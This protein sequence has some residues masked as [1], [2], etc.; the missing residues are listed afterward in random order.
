[1][2]RH[3]LNR[4]ER[5]GINP[6]NGRENFIS[7]MILTVLMV[8][9][10]ALVPKIDVADNPR[11]RQGK[12]LSIW[13]SWHGA[14]AKVVEQNVTSRIEGLVSAVRGVERVT[15]ESYFGSGRVNVELKKSADV[16]AT[17]FE[18][19]SLLRQV[20]EQLPEGVSYPELSGGEVVNESRKKEMT[21]VLLSYRV[22][23][24][25][26]DEQLKEYI[27]RQVEPQLRRIE[28][29]KRVEVTGGHSKYIVITYDP[30]ILA[31][32]GLSVYDIENGIKAFLGKCDVVGELQEPGKEEKRT[33]FLTTDKFHG[34]LEEMP[35]GNV[36]G[37]TVYLND[38]ATYEYKDR[39]PGSYYRVNGL[40]TIYLNIHVDADANK[41]KLSRKLRKQIGEIEKTLRGGVYL[42]L[43]HDGAEEKVS[44][45]QKLIWRSMLSLAILLLF[46]WLVRR[47]WRYLS[48]MVITLAANIALAVIAYYIFDIRLHIY[49]LAGITVSLGMVIDASVVMVDHYSYYH[50]RKAFM[51]IL[52]ALLTTIGALVVVLW[53]PDFLQKD[54]YDFAWII[55]VNLSVALVVAYFF[56]PALIEQMR[57]HSRQKGEVKRIGLARWW[58]RCYR[59]YIRFTQKRKWIYFVILL[60]A[61]GIP[62]HLLPAKWGK[63]SSDYWQQPADTVPDPWYAQA[64]NATFG[65]DFFQRDC[66]EPLSK[67]FGGTMRL[68]S[69]SLS[70]NTYSRNEEKEIKLN[71][72][73]Q[74][75]LGGTAAQLNEKVVIL[76]NFLV[77]FPEIER[78]E[79]R[80]ESWGATVTVEFKEEYR[81]TSF[82]YLLENKVIGK[83]ISI[84]GADW[85]TSG[86]SE[87]GFSNSL[88]LQYRSNRIEIVGYNYDRLYRIA[89]D[90]CDEMRRNNRV[91]DLTI[92][93][94]GHENQEDELYM[95]Y[96]KEK[97]ALYNFDIARAH[98]TLREILSGKDIDRYRDTH[99]TS[100]M[101]LKSAWQDRFDLWQLDNSLLRIGDTES[102]ISDYMTIG[103]R[104]AKNCIPRQNQ[105]YVLHVAFN[106]LGSY[107]YTSRYIKN[108]TEEFNRKVP[109]GYRC[110]NTSYGFYQDDGTQYWL[111]G[112]IVVIIF[113]VCSIL[114]ESLRQPLA[115]I[116]LIPVSFIG[117]FLTYYLTGLEF[118]TGGFASMVLL[119]GLTVNAGIYILC[120][121]N[122]QRE[123]YPAVS[124]LKCYLRAYSHKVTA[125]F[126]TT[127]STV[128]GLVPFYIDGAKDS[129]WF[130]FAVGSTGGLL[131]SILA[132]VLVMPIFI[133]LK[134]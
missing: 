77:T 78:F 127:L 7:L 2:I 59:A 105:E 33:L 57:Y 27:E 121:Y 117:T 84:G 68:F 32:Y 106:M 102:R 133:R 43:T 29:V 60:M 9:G 131:F 116:S 100:D 25:L 44:E 53:L 94:P 97:I 34:E 1:M 31:S 107:T 11:P 24:N 90:M 119:C 71:I 76:E 51:A 108:I 86:V 45:L 39:L 125:V 130:S 104:E 113:F 37:K 80:V 35:V 5:V 126:L 128:L 91:V 96:D 38:L 72:R 3:I 87:R 92:E 88:N 36:D 46:V 18:I 99:F 103:R 70:G 98:S 67:V 42:T 109:V 48:I 17:K 26:S 83:V 4:T 12:T 132:L 16:S 110:R 81:K 47:D 85:S 14:S 79:T 112:L 118:G 89:E 50:D 49:S 28:D 95:R 101:Y 61:F 8:I 58:N 13:Y 6:S 64:Y 52:A 129:F 21:Q 10:C 55:I 69:E 15:S 54:L 75:P 73:A 19:A 40:N 56:A 66:K 20:R 30:F 82:P 63:S 122:N 124:A 115:I 120:E 41:I 114:F 62:F 93:T 22:N 23:S 65:S 111:L 134:K 74:M 123:A